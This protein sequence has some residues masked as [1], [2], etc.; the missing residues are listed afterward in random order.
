MSIGGTLAEARERAG[1]SVEEVA[2]AT[3]IRRA[4]ITAMEQDDFSGMGGDF[5]ARGHLRTVA[6]KLGLD[7]APLLKEFDATRPVPSPRAS[8]VFEAETIRPDRRGPNWSAAMAAALVLILIYGIA[9][10]V[11]GNSRP[12]EDAFPGTSGSTS[13]SG[14][15]SR[16]PS[17]TPS[18]TGSAIARAPR[19]RVT[20]VL[21]AR[22]TSWVQATTA[23]GKQLFEG[24][25]EDRTL[26]FTDRTL[27]RLVVGN[28]G[29]VSLTV[30]GR[31]L[32]APGKPGEVARVEFTRE[33]PAAG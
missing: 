21:T 7:P 30:N 25:V 6:T 20:V 1:L 5:Y 26:T 22:G 33:D 15:T 2:Q 14:S 3:R 11:T 17:T 4:L 18:P 8:E 10:V 12:A 13:D 32:G 9:Q 19:D 23:T 24:I 28:A 27:V 16:S 31:E 29:A